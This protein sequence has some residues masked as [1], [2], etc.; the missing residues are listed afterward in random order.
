[1]FIGV[2]FYFLYIKIF[3]IKS[4][5]KSAQNREYMIDNLEHDHQRG[6]GTTKHSKS[7]RT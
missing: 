3:I 6:L 2:L 1:M 7:L 5:L 4:E